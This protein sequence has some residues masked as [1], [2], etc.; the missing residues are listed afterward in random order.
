MVGDTI[1]IMLDM[2]NVRRVHK[3]LIS[4]FF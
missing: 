1:G 4:D 3:F 2:V